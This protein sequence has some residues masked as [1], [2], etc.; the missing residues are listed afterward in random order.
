MKLPPEYLDAL[1]KQTSDDLTGEFKPY[2]G[3]C[4]SSTAEPT[5][6]TMADLDKLAETVTRLSLE[7]RVID[8]RLADWMASQ[9]FSPELGGML[10]LPDVEPFKSVKLS[11]PKFVMV[12]PHVSAPTLFNNPASPY[13]S[14]KLSIRR[15]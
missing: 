4:T 5:A 13:L 6:I 15:L 12:S 14:E 3:T 11:Y 7:K 2:G 1:L 8:D 9:G 10:Y